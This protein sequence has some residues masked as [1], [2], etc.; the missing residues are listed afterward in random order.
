MVAVMC[1]GNIST[2]IA[3]WQTGNLMQQVGSM[4]LLGRR[5]LIVLPQ[6]ATTVKANRFAAQAMVRMSDAM[7]NQPGV[8]TWLPID[9]AVVALILDVEDLCAAADGDLAVGV[10]G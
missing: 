1:I 7:A 8:E 6:A 2:G 4:S 3:G 10:T 9:T 5:C